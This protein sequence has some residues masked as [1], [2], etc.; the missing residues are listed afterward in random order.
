[1][2]HQRTVDAMRTLGRFLNCAGELR[3]DRRGAALIEFAA[4]A[5]LLSGLL[6]P[7]ADLGMG[8]YY[9]MQVMTAAEAGA[10]YAFKKGWTTDSTT[11]QTNICT[12]VI[13][14]ASLGSSDSCSGSTNT[15]STALVYSANPSTN[16]PKLSSPNF[17]LVCKCTDGRTLNPINPT[18]GLSS[19]FTP[20][21]C[22]TLSSSYCNYG[23]NNN[24]TPGAYV[25]VR[26]SFTY[27]PLLRYPGFGYL[28]GPG[29]N[30]SVTLQ[31]QSTVRI[32]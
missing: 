10:Q 13:N 26:T 22:T 23:S 2:F 18:S 15:G 12:S 27:Q 30:G 32:Q 11:T 8:F 7:L 25:T 28:W 19:T 14:A 4:V 31:G 20:S 3:R 29:Y 17:Q 6:L 5:T 1:M 16:D 9:K 24:Q 21:Q